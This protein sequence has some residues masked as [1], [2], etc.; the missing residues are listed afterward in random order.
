MWCFVVLDGWFDG[1]MPLPPSGYNK[2]AK[3]G[4]LPHD[5]TVS[6]LLLAS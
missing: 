6:T 3:E 5:L 1:E 2:R 4:G